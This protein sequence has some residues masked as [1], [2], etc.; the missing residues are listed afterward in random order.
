[1]SLSTRSGFNNLLK[2][3]FNE[4]KGHKHYGGLEEAIIK[5]I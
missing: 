1:M 2:E 5:N 4:Y 3:V